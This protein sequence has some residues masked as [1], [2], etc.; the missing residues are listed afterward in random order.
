MKDLWDS[1]ALMMHDAAR[2]THE[3]VQGQGDRAGRQGE[4]ICTP[5][6]TLSV[7][8]GSPALPIKTGLSIF[9]TLLYWSFCPNELYVEPIFT[10][11]EL[12]ASVARS[13]RRVRPTVG[14]WDLSRTS[15]GS[16]LTSWPLKGYSP[17]VASR[18]I[19]PTVGH[20]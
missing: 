10:Q 11:A 19:Y 4:R 16:Y 7:T 17:E 14:H 18:L 9:D 13:A 6:N 3:R 15:W 20:T 2:Q 5:R 12:G 1:K 8:E